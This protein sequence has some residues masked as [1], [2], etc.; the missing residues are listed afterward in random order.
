MSRSRTR[1][2]G[3]RRAISWIWWTGWDDDS[4]SGCLKPR[5][6]LE[7]RAPIGLPL[8]RAD[9]GDVGEVGV[10]AGPFQRHFAQG[11]VV[12]DDIGRHAR[13][14]GEVAAAGAQGLEQ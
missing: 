3:R 5:D 1:R 14:L 11:A 4:G 7:K 10:R 2:I 12:E 6:H 8:A 13:F 9:A